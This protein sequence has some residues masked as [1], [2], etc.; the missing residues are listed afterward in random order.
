MPLSWRGSETTCC[1]SKNQLSL[2]QDV[3]V[4]FAEPGPPQAVT[5]HQGHGRLERRELRASD[6]LAGYSVQNQETFSAWATMEGRMAMRPYHRP[7]PYD[8]P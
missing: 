4:L 2:Y 1:G 8:L 5:V 3:A 6:A 7:I